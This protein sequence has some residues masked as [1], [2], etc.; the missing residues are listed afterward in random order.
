MSDAAR[1]GLKSGLCVTFIKKSLNFPFRLPPP[2]PHRALLAGRD[3]SLPAL[4]PAESPTV[5]TPPLGRARA[6]RGGLGSRSAPAAASARR[7]IASK[8]RGGT[9]GGRGRGALDDSG[10]SQDT[11]AAATPANGLLL[12]PPDPVGGGGEKEPPGGGPGRMC[13][14]SANCGRAW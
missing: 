6:T 3:G 8:A 13:A 9:P 2:H 1:S 11:L 10:E 4:S 12:R 14:N 5:V 7:R